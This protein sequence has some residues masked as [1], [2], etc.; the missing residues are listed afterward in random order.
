MQNSPLKIKSRTPLMDQKHSSC[1]VK[2]YYQKQ[3]S[4][5]I[6]TEGKVSGE[7]LSGQHRNSPDALTNQILVEETAEI[8]NEN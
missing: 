7:K 3:T 1:V 8:Q 6:A 2:V 5:R 4:R